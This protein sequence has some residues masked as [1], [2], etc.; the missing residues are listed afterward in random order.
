MDT[1]SQATLKQALLRREKKSVPGSTTSTT[2]EPDGSVPTYKPRDFLVV[3][4]DAALSALL[5]KL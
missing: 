5:G 1:T 3:N 2:P 4:F